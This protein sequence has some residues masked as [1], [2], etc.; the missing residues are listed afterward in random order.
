MMHQLHFCLPALILLAIL[1]CEPKIS[2]PALTDDLVYTNSAGMRFV[3]PG[4]LGRHSEN[5]TFPMFFRPIPR[6]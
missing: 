4:T 2:A 6:G 1:G 5:R 3:V